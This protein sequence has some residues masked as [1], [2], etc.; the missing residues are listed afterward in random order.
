MAW[1]AA[2]AA[3]G[4]AAFVEK[5]QELNLGQIIAANE[6]AA[7]T[8]EQE[9]RERRTDIPSQC[10]GVGGAYGIQSRLIDGA[11]DWLCRD[12]KCSRRQKE[13]RLRY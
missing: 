9:G 1:A 10:A 11:M 4:A 6:Q 13:R 2:I 3:F 12:I 5:E 8:H 7:P